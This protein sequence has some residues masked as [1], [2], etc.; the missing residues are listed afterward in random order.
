M[1][2]SKYSKQILEEAVSKSRSLSELVRILTKSDK[3][4]GSMIAHIKN[5]LIYHKINY[6]HFDGR[7][8][9]FFLKKN[10]PF[11]NS[12]EDVLKHYF[13]SSPTKFTCGTNLK[14]WLFKFGI[15]ENKCFVCGINPKWNNMYLSL[16]LDHVD[17]NNRNNDLSNL[18]ILCPN[19]HSQTKN[20]AGKKNKRRNKQIA[21]DCT[22]LEN[23]RA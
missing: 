3:A 13:T 17:G 16:Q 9:A 22:D 19:C 1:K 20:Y 15:L 6:S 5:K 23:R 7:S 10:G 2:N 11:E 21:G 8:K 4:H 14:K 18:R 12:K